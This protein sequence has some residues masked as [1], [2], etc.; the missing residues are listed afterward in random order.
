[1]LYVKKY[2]TFKIKSVILYDIK[3][4]FSMIEVC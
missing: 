3:N 1:M 2:L 4:F